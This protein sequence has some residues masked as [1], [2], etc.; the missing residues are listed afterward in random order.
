MTIY[1]RWGE[2]I[3]E[4]DDIAKR[5]DG[6]Y[7]NKPVPAGSYFYIVWFRDR[8]MKGHALNGSVLLLR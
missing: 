6:N 1:N 7:Q 4:S 3:F 5:W 2:K 8:T